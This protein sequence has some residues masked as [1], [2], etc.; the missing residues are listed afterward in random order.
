[1][2]DYPRDH[3][4]HEIRI[5]EQ[6]L[7]HRITGV[8]SVTVNSLHHQAVDRLADGLVATAWTADGIVEGLELDTQ[9]AAAGNGGRF[10]AGVQFHPEDIQ[11][12]ETMRRLFAH[13]LD[14]ARDY[15]D[16]RA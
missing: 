9:A 14:A 4:A 13:F 1:M 11:E 3:L 2:K 16:Q 7:L 15:R 5:A 6:S 10:V 12:Y 8:T